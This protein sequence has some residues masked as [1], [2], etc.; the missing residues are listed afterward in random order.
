MMHTKID[1]TLLMDYEGHINNDL[2]IRLRQR[3][4]VTHSY[5]TLDRF[6][7]PEDVYPQNKKSFLKIEVS[8]ISVPFLQ[9]LLTPKS[10][11]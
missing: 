5:T 6:L 4:G 9:T 8:P 10:L 7:L 2:Y 1:E 3:L 11:N